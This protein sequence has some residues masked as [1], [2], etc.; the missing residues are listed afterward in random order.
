MTGEALAATPEA[1]GSLGTPPPAATTEAARPGI[2]LVM[3]E[4]FKADEAVLGEFKALAQEAGLDS[5]K[6]Q[7]LFG[8][9]MKQE[10]A[11]MKQAEEGLM[12]RDT[13][14][15]TSV[16]ADRTLGKDEAE[17]QGHFRRGILAMPGG[18]GVAEA[19]H[20]LGLGNHPALV[21]AFVEL[22][23]KQ[24]EDSVQ[25]TVSGATNTA[26][27]EKS[28]SEVMHNNTRRS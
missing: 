13:D 12:Q 14:W 2:E 22:G 27:E 28:W 20:S 11:R 21:K 16:L 8:V 5:P 9:F 10:Q 15:R 18:R 25:K 4:G 19:I 26:T 17:I 24:S 6:A 3:P 23:K 7:K 1:T